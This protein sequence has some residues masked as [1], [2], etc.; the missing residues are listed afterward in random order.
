MKLKL[1]RVDVRDVVV[2][3]ESES[4][5]GISYKTEIYTGEMPGMPDDI[6]LFK[7]VEVAETLKEFRELN[8]LTKGDLVEW[9]N[10]NYER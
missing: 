6:Q 7:E 4:C 10:L 5:H 2:T 3:A 1:V 8:G 9:L